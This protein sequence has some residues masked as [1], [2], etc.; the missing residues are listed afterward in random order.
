MTS[1]DSRPGPGEKADCGS[2]RPGGNHTRFPPGRDAVPPGT[3]PHGDRAQ[4]TISSWRGT[5]E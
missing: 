4:D 5:P 2:H 1:A 3:P